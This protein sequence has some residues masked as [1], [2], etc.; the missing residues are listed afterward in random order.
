MI[1]HPIKHCLYTPQTLP[2]LFIPPHLHCQ[3]PVGVA[4]QKVAGKR[5]REKEKE[6]DKGE[7]LFDYFSGTSEGQ[8]AAPGY[9]L[10]RCIEETVL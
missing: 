1:P 4:R 8:T 5:M 9:M 2:L 3:H 10:I 6:A 7:I